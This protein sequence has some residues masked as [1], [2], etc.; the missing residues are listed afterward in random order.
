M[1]SLSFVIQQFDE[2]SRRSQFIKKN[3]YLL[4]FILIV[5]KISIIKLYEESFHTEKVV[6]KLNV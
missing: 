4:E 2:M 3:F 5:T 1:Q 6:L